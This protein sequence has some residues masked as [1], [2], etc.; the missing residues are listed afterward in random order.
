MD[1]RPWWQRKRLIDAIMTGVP[2]LVVVLKLFG[3]DITD[4]SGILTQGLLDLLRLIGLIAAT[5]RRRRSK[6]VGS[7]RDVPLV[8]RHRSLRPKLRER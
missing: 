1:T 8:T 3:I 6:I 2:A 4:L 5:C 7:T